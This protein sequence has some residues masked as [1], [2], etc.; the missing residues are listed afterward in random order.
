MALGI[1]MLK[2]IFLL[3]LNCKHMTH[4]INMLKNIHPCILKRT[5]LISSIPMCYA[6][7]QNESIPMHFKKLL[8]LTNSVI[9][10]ISGHDTLRPLGI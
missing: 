1:N 6:R 5:T 3:Q 9:F 4:A 2:N 10:T 8:M 7:C